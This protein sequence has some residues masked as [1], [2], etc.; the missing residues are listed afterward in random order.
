MNDKSCIF[1]L[2][3][4]AR[5][6]LFEYLLDKGE[7]PNISEYIVERGSYSSGVTVFPSTTGPA[8]T[9]YLLGKFPGRCNL[10]GIRW[11]D[12]YQ[13]AQSRFSLKGVRSYIGP[14]TYLINSD[15]DTNG[16]PTLFELIPRS[17]SI[18]N[19]ITRGLSSNR[20]KTKFKKVFL[21]IKSHFTDSSNE[22]D[23]AG[24]RLLLN[25]LT[26][27]PKFL[28]CVFMGIDTY[29]HQFHP[30]HKKVINSYKF[31]DNYVGKIVAYLRK[32]DRLADTLIAIGSDHGL[33]PTHSHFDTP[34]FMDNL[35]Y[36][37]LYHTNIFN[38]LIDADASV[39]V[40]GN[41]MAHIYIKSKDGWNRNAF[42]DETENVVN[43]LLGRNEIDIVAGIRSDSKVGIKSA[44]G[45]AITW[46]ENGNIMYKVVGNDPFGYKKI[47]KK[48]T[49]ESAFKYTYDSNYPDA[50]VQLLQLFESRRTGDLLISAKP[51]IDL[52]ARH[53]HPE[54][55]GSHG[56]LVKSHMMVPI[57]MN[58]KVNSSYVRSS[59]IYP[60]ILKY[61]DIE[62][63]SGIDGKSLI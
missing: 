32:E 54:H 8:Y 11:F 51:G 56:S 35:G 9:P 33:T 52:R 30:F 6:D 7:L 40:S 29:S 2:A 34:L 62:I 47:P 42:M 49:T 16:T 10:P 58:K 60:T 25:S 39:M 15:L 5:A 17:V 19:E 50:I 36:K 22:V 41:S 3:D 12:R 38:H 55:C 18:L 43:E 27:K 31:I 53:E 63:P 59:D 20:D 1:I 45:E 44:R 48:L 46:S 14:E 61:L 57:V 24:G 26:E 37:T 13:F 21:K 28:F 23:E 4:G